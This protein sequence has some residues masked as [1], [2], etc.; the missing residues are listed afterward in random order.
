MIDAPRD[1]MG[2]GATAEKGPYSA[3]LI[4]DMKAVRL[5]AAQTAL[6]SKPSLVLDLLAFRTKRIAGGHLALVRRLR[7]NQVFP[8]SDCHL[9][10]A[11]EA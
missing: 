4:E 1:G 7:D 6:L 11:P 2:N 5:N 10:D 8:L 9:L 3:K